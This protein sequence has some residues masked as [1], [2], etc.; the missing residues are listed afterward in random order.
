M[1][2][3]L[4][5]SSYFKSIATIKSKGQAVLYSLPYLYSSVHCALSVLDI[6]W[7]SLKEVNLAKNIELNC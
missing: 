7:E 4:S 6:L 2:G 1:I 5:G 3:A